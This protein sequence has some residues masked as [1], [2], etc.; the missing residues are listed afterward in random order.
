MSSFVLGK[1]NDLAKAFAQIEK[2]INVNNIT[3]SD[4]IGRVYKIFNFKPHLVYL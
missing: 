1:Q 2:T 3:Y 4:K